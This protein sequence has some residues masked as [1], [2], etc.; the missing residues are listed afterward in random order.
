[1]QAKSIP[2]KAGTEQVVALVRE[3]DRQCL[4]ADSSARLRA[5]VTLYTQNGGVLPV[6]LTPEPV[7]EG[8]PVSQ[9][10]LQRHR[11]LDEGFRLQSRAFM[12]TFNSKAFTAGTWERFRTWVQGTARRLHASRWAACL[13]ES[14]HA[15][16]SADASV[17]HTHAYLWWT[18]GKGV[19]HRN[20][21]EFVFDA[22]RPRVD[23][24]VHQ[25]PKARTFSLAAT[26]GMWYVSVVKLGTLFADSN[27]KAWRD[28]EPRV[29]WVR[30]LWG[31]R[32][33]THAMFED[34]SRRLRVGHADR[35]RDLT[36]LYADERQ[37]AV[38][39]HV[40]TAEARTSASLRPLRSFQQVEEF[41]ESFKHASLLRRPILAIV[42]GTNLGK[43]ILAADVLKRVGKCLNVPSFLE[44]IV[45][46]DSF[47]D[48]TDFDVRCHAGVLLD[49]VGNVEILKSN[50]EVLQ[51]RAK[52]CKAGRSPT[53][54]FSTMYS[55]HRRAV[56][57]S[58]D[59]SADN[60]HL[61]DSDHWLSNPSNVVCLKLTSPAWV[62]PGEVPQ[63]LRE[64]RAQQM[65]SWPVS[66]VVAF[67]KAR[68]LE[69]PAATLFASGVTGADLVETSEG[70]LVHEVR[71]TPFA[72]AKVI[73]ARE[74]V[75]LRGGQRATRSQC[76]WQPKLCPR[77]DERGETPPRDGGEEQW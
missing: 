2:V 75:V 22:V 10:Q 43:S 39:D 50:R 35:K 26:Q 44:V 24:C 33:L 31:T 17:F 69:G 20:T 53:M 25:G 76:P 32:K 6:R 12:L 55:L 34:Y 14:Q 74:G 8:A 27:F 21:D 7:G 48:L 3:L 36:E 73:R 45:E 9:V 67:A 42:G 46:G 49:G 37:Q 11:V 4:D 40:G 62:Q 70:L 71:L 57:A 51:G 18:D 60:L 41:I 68:D 38:H 13:E 65:R 56:V 52:L 15:Q 54:R 58:F 63:E 28:Y 19:R 77:S 66:G 47:L 1:M 64:N 59:L 29:E 16:A 23:V 5:A 61:L 30:G 72:A